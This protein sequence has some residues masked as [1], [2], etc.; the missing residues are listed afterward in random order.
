[1]NKVTGL[2][3]VLLGLLSV[4]IDKD[5]TVLILF[6]IIGFVIYRTKEVA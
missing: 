6:A 2:L 5:A 1:M 4:G 3:F